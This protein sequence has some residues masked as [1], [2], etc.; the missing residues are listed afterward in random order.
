[1]S[2][3]RAGTVDI[4]TVT[5]TAVCSG[6]SFNFETVDGGTLLIWTNAIGITSVVDSAGAQWP[7]RLVAMST[8]MW[9]F[10]I[11][12]AGAGANGFSSSAQWTVNFAAAVSGWYA[13]VQGTPY[14]PPLPVQVVTVANPAAG[15]NWSYKLPFP[16]RVAH[17]GAG[18]VTSSTAADRYPYMNFLSLGGGANAFDGLPAGSPMTAG[19][20]YNLSWQAGSGFVPYFSPGADAWVAAIPDYG[21]LPAGTVIEAGVSG[22]QAGDQWSAINL[23]LEPA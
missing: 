20:G 16:A 23:E 10:A 11:P 5:G 7:Y 6:T 21:V 18:F 19:A 8:G 12:L 2:T 4:S 14:M 22:L 3:A 1:M 9:C 13:W 17:I 15:A